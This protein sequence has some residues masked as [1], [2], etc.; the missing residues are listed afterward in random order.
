M[1]I[2]TRAVQVLQA[3]QRLLQRTR[4]L[5]SMS[6]VH[7]HVQPGG[8]YVCYSSS[9]AQRFRNALAWI[10]ALCSCCVATWREAAEH[11]GYVEVSLAAAAAN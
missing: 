7:V 6:Q 9:S 10:V 3:L 1:L 5:L 4:R 2:D 8:V 11:G